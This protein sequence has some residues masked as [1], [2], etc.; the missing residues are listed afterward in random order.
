MDKPITLE[1]VI[2][3][4]LGTPLFDGLDPTQLAD[5]VRIMQMQRVRDAHD[6]F[7][8]GDEGDAWFVVFR[9]EVVVSKSSPFGPPRTVAVLGPRSCFGEMAVLDGSER[10]AGVRVRGDATLFRFPRDA[11]GRLVDEGNVGAYKLVFAMARVLSQ[12]LRGL[13][14]QLS[15]AMTDGTVGDRGL[16]T[17]LGPLLDSFTVSE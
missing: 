7:R 5:V 11:F 8:E 6:I 12:R 17:S 16:R 1:E 10:S 14:Q 15:D 4:L 9:G 3:F 2:D 13:T